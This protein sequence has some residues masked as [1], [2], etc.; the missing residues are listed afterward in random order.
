[1]TDFADISSNN[2][3]GVDLR[4]YRAAGY[5]RIAVKA[6]E[7]D[8]YTNPYLAQWRDL[9]HQLGLEVWLYHF[10]RPGIDGTTEARYFMQQIGGL[11]PGEVPVIDIEG[12]G[13]LGSEAEDDLKAF[14][15]VVGR[16][17]M[18]YAS[19][20]FI[21][22]EGLWL[23][24]GWQWWIAKWGT[25]PPRLPYAAWQFTE[26][27]SAPGIGVGHVDMSHPGVAV[28]PPAP[29]PSPTI[30]E[31]DEDDMKYRLYRIAEN[32]NPVYAMRPGLV[33]HVSKDDINALVAAKQ[34]DVD[35]NG[36]AVVQRV[37]QLEFNLVKGLAL[38]TGDRTQP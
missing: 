14:A 12:T 9:A 1:V 28:T 38:A 27:G 37:S 15:A 18:C 33:D 26:T 35:A 31:G 10:A 19:E 6:T 3:S 20:S 11:R 17:G 16:P 30:P 24:T 36:A 2:G 25:T 22:D 5:T 7:R 13:W 4:A 32:P 34:V 29:A 8:D 21:G 23:P